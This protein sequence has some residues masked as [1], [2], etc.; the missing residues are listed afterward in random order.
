MSEALSEMKNDALPREELHPVRGAALL[1]GLHRVVPLGR[2]YHPL[3][4]LMNPSHGLLSIPFERNRV[5]QPA[6]WRKQTATLLLMGRGMIPE[7]SLLAPICRGLKSGAMI[8]VG[9]NIGLYTLSLRAESPLPI[10]AYEP[11]PFLFKLL[12]WNIAFNELPD[13]EARNLA[14]GAQRGEV[15]FALGI[16]G[17][18]VAP[19]GENARDASVIGDVEGWEKEALVTQR[20]KALIKVPLVTLDEDLANVPEISL[21]KIDCE[22]F[23]CGILEGAQKLIAKHKPV[24]FLEAHPPVLGMY[25]RTVREVLDLVAPHYDLEFWYYQLEPRSSK[26]KQSLAKFR[27][28]RARQCADAR[29]MLELCDSDPQPPQLYF[30]GR[31]K[32]KSQP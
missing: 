29:A 30:I 1:R 9:A 24:L 23:E 19:T 11:Q 27:R 12:Q 2:K 7:F 8:D 4:G 25:G 31:P 28:P 21:L 26:F 10:I 3:L 20:G 13:I 15:P 17:S 14:C 18:V 6:A 16:N 32:N 22:G 5:I